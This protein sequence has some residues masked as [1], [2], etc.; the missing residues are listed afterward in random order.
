M[1]ASSRL[2]T[3]RRSRRVTT[4]SAAPKP[5]AGGAAARSV[6][7]DR[8]SD[9]GPRHDADRHA[10]PVDDRHGADPECGQQGSYVPE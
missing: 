7:L 6:A 8:L 4:L 1:T 10:E 9:V 5:T 2:W 3:F